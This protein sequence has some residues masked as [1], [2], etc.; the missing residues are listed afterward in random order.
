MME[1]TNGYVPLKN[2]YVKKT[3][4]IGFVACETLFYFIIFCQ[5]RKTF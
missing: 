2:K 5:N 1:L 3:Q 4:F